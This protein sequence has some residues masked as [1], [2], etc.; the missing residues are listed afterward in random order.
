MMLSSCQRLIIIKV[1]RT[2]GMVKEIRTNSLSI[3]KLNAPSNHS[4][5]KCLS[6]SAIATY[7]T[8]REFYQFVLF[9]AQ[10]TA[11]LSEV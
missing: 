1:L 9:I 10:F 6:D 11:K 4:D 7:M 3:R 5:I 2:S 8:H